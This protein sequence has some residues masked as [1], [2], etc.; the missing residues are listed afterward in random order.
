MKFIR[1][2]AATIAVL[3][4]L[5]SGVGCD[6]KSSGGGDN[7][8]GTT[9]GSVQI[10]LGTVNDTLRFLPG[11]SASTVV[12]VI[13][14]D[15]QGR[16]LPGVKVDL[17]LADANLGYIEWADDNLRDTTNS[18]GRVNATF[19]TYARAGAQIISATVGGLTENRVLTI[20]QAANS[21]CFLNMVVADTLLDANPVVEDS[22]QVILTITD[23]DYNGVPGVSLDLRANGGRL[24]PPLPT[25]STG[26][27]TTWW[28]NNGQFG[29]F[30]ISIE[31]GDITRSVNVV[32]QE[33]DRAQ[34][35]LF[36]YTDRKIVE[37]DGCV[38]AATIQAQ[39][40][41]QYGE[42]IRG[43]TVRFGTPNGGAVNPW[44]VTDTLGIAEVT[45]CGMGVP[46]G[47]DPA[48]SALII[49]RYDK[50]SLRDTVNVRIAPASAIG[51]V[52]LSATNTFGVAG[53]DSIELI[54][55]VFFENGARVNG[56]WAR[57]RFTQCGDLTFDSVRLVNG[58]PDTANFY[59]LCT[60]VPITAPQ[61]TA[62]VGGVMSSPL[63]IQIN[64][65]VANRLTFPTAIPTLSIGQQW[66]VEAQ[67]QDTFQNPVGA[68]TV[69]FFES[70]LGAV[71]P[72]TATTAADG[73]A[74]SNYNSGTTAGSG[75]V[76]ARLGNSYV[77]STTVFVQAGDP[78]SLTMTL[79]PTSLQVRGSGGQDWA[80]IE[81]RAFDPNGNPVPDG[82]WVTFELLDAPEGC[83]I[84]EHGSLDSAQTAAGLAIATLNAG[85]V[86]GP[87]NVQACVQA[88]SG[89]RCVPGSAT[90]VAGPPYEIQMGLNEVGV[91]ALGAAWDLELS[92]LVKDVVQNPVRNGTAVFFEVVPEE[93]A[94]VLSEFVVTGNENSAGD[95]HPG[96][97]YTTL[98]F[99]SLATNQTIQITATTANGIIETMDFVLPIQEPGVELYCVPGSWHFGA[100]GNPCHIELR[101]VV[102]DGH[103]VLING[104]TVY[105]NAQRGRMYGNQNGTGP[106]L[107]LAIT[108]PDFGAPADGECSL[109]L[110]EQE[111]F[112]FPDDVTP[113]IPGTVFAE[114]LGY[115]IA[116]DNQTISFRR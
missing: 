26:R 57:F 100:N 49:A 2:T 29:T 76:R 55:N 7:N 82:T 47:E 53:R 114:V 108:G 39:L 95:A 3:A 19:R 112:I 58:S 44:A 74:R 28:F 20:L 50:W 89:E 15:Q 10:V 96:I 25:D 99:T 92:A 67:V 110:V 72:T 9:P 83:N 104:Q 113:E 64:P 81:A 79:N 5:L 38:S 111:N 59:R 30:T 107:S 62:E 66:I 4:M 61:I 103:E 102:R 52:N 68:G 12:T 71:S 65:G 23:C 22:T 1:W 40:Q 18:L 85:T 77:D 91:D 33:S 45:F 115:D 73:I 17:S 27:T 97:A 70:T 13:V 105:Y 75:V 41:N 93:Y 46:N 63:T 116:Q 80:Q 51:E 16:A 56:Y 43:D 35:Y 88:I 11:D 86:V 101:A 37:A 94:Q 69:V 90:V 60:Q 48:D 8:N 54:L 34:G 42:A 98:R 21:I 84:N 78:N 14:S 109:W 106:T 87:V 6:E 36:V 24:T 31:I 32:V